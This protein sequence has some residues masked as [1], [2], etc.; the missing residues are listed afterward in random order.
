MWVFA[1]FF[2]GFAVKV[3]VF[4]LHTWLPDAHVE[5][6]VAASVLLAGILLKMGTYGF[7]RVSLPMLPDAA[8][9]WAPWIAV[10][11]AVSI[12][13]GA[14]VAFAQTDIKKLVAYSSVSHMGFVMLGIASMTSAGLQGAVA[15]MFSHGVLTGML[16]LLVGMVY[17]RTHTREIKLLAGM[18]SKVPVLGGILAFASIGSLGLPGLSGF[19]GEFLS[20]LGAWQSPL[21]PHWITIFSAIGVL[22]AAAYMLYMML[23]VVLGEASEKIAAIT[24]ATPLEIATLLPL[25]VLTVVVGVWWASLLG[26]AEPAVSSIVAVLAKAG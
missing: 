10:L 4:P 19:V 20:L 9:T 23:R 3:P 18:S 24:D 16:F 22:L 8:A 1:L 21:I 13:Y 25:M 14:A 17:D 6:P 15:I 12:V 11:A 26:Y 7:I 2:L 5:A